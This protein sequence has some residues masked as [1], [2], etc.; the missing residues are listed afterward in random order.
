MPRSLIHSNQKQKYLTSFRKSGFH[1]PRAQHLKLLNGLAMQTIPYSGFRIFSNPLFGEPLVLDSAW[2]IRLVPVAFNAISNVYVDSVYLTNPF[3][4]GGEKI[5]Y[6]FACTTAARNQ[7]K[8]LY[9][10]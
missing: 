2:N 1:L 3:I 8:A 9:R 7:S 10:A 6:K 5:L 4:I